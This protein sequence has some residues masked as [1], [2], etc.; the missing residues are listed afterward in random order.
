MRSHLGPGLSLGLSLGDILDSMGQEDPGLYKDPV[1]YPQHGSHGSYGSRD[2]GYGRNRDYHG[3][4]GSGGGS[5]HPGRGN[6]RP[7]EGRNRVLTHQPAMFIPHMYPP[8][9]P[10]APIVSAPMPIPVLFQP[11]PNPHSHSDSNCSALLAVVQEMQDLTPYVYHTLVTDPFHFLLEN[12]SV[13]SVPQCLELLSCTVLEVL[14][15][16]SGVSGSSGVGNRDIVAVWLTRINAINHTNTPDM[17]TI[18]ESIQQY[19][20]HL[21]FISQYSS[22]SSNSSGSSSS[23]NSNNCDSDCDS[24]DG[25]GMGVGLSK[26]QLLELH[27]L[28]STRELIGLLVGF[29]LNYLYAGKL[30]NLK[31]YIRILQIF[32]NNLIQFQS[33]TQSQSQSQS[34]SHGSGY[35]WAYIVCRVQDCINTACIHQYNATME[36]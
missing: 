22:S 26:D 20:Y 32:S 10:V 1:I 5:R 23:G 35:D 4:S 30:S 16:D 15:G 27:H 21:Y 13:I 2:Q 7:K 34:Q 19:M 17:L 18:S 36:F 29:G 28:P 31:I 3:S 33:E 25:M 9:A 8:A 14:D 11:N 6:T 12:Y 24:D